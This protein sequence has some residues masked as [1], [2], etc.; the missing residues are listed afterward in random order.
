MKDNALSGIVSQGRQGYSFH[1]SLAEEYSVSSSAFA[2]PFTST[3]AS[4][5]TSTTAS[6]S[7]SA[8]LRTRSHSG[9]WVRRFLGGGRERR[10][11]LGRVGQPCPNLL[12]L[13]T[14][15]P[16]VEQVVLRLTGKPVK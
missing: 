16:S 2:F 11:V 15:I 9:R 10:Y 3:T 4:T 13:V 12:V 14:R 8:R 7:A 1:F 5:S 6:T